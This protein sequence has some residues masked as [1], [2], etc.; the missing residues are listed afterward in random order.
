M[1]DWVLSWLG[2]SPQRYNL[3]TLEH[4]RQAFE[5]R[6][7]FLQRNIHEEYTS[8]G[9]SDSQDWFDPRTKVP[10]VSDIDNARIRIIISSWHPSRLAYIREWQ[11][12]AYVL[13][14]IDIAI[15]YISWALTQGPDT[16]TDRICN[17][18]VTTI[19]SFPLTAADQ[20]VRPRP[21]DAERIT[22]RRTITDEPQVQ[23]LLAEL[24]KG[25]RAELDAAAERMR[26]RLPL[27]P[28]CFKDLQPGDKLVESGQRQH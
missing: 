20:A 10:V 9:R 8:R 25:R 16:Q 28:A 24:D 26:A 14:C 23:A 11:Q 15:S 19:L 18:M 4:I 12:A 3:Q 13:G 17:T 5:N 22:D 21:D 1:F 2:Y 7:F 6:I 27:L